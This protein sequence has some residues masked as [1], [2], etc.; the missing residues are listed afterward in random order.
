MVNRMTYSKFVSE[1]SR[2]QQNLD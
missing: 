1:R 2:S